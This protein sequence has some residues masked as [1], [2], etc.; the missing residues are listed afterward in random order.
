MAAMAPNSSDLKLRQV[1]RLGHSPRGIVVDGLILLFNKFHSL[2]IK[3]KSL[4]HSRQAT[5]AWP[6]IQPKL[7]KTEENELKEILKQF[8]V[9]SEHYSYGHGKWRIDETYFR[10]NRGKEQMWFM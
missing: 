4:F 6:A 5:N 1:G 7:T 2:F 10:Q 8:H 3:F 9:S